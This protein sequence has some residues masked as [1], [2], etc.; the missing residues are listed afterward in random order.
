MEACERGPLSVVEM[1]VNHDKGLLEFESDS[2]QT[3]LLYAVEN[4]HVDLVRFLLDRGA[5][6]HGT[7]QGART[8]LMVV[9]QE[10]GNLDI[11]RLLL[12]AGSNVEAR[13]AF[14]QT[15]LHHA[16]SSRNVEAVRAL[17]LQHNA[18]MF[19]VDNTGNTP[20]DR[21]CYCEQTPEAA[22]LLLEIFGNK[23]T[24]EHGRLTLHELL[25]VAEYS[26]AETEDLYP[27]PNTLRICIPLGTLTLT[28]WRTLV[29]SFDMELIR[30]R[31]DNGKLPI[32]IACRTDP[33]LNSP[34]VVSLSLG[35]LAWKHLRTLVQYIGTAFVRNRDDNGNSSTHLACRTNTPL[36]VLSALVDLDS[37]T[38]QIADYSGNLPLHDCCFGAVDHSSVQYLVEQGGVGTLAA[39]NRQG[40]LPLHILCGSKNPPLRTVQY[41]I[42]SFPESVAAQTDSGEYP[43]M[44]AAAE[45]SSASL[46][47]VYELVRAKPDL[48]NP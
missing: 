15:A 43:F 4:G 23:M 12:A 40:L 27:P 36:E 6:V 5:N 14:Q 25:K 18:N 7:P 34:L 13:D 44:I 9:C 8:T 42:Q 29:Q 31:D 32:H 22:E 2:K 17:I 38:L 47:V 46:S 3:P 33:P 19:A 21:A 30:N 45:I 26:F 48:V 39:R 35:E 28:H 24:Q 20:F 37:A 1:L 16:A 41:S 11:L 10:T